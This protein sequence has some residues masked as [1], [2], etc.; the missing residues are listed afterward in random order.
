MKKT[1]ILILVLLPIILV[2]TIAFA[3]KILSYYHHIP[4]EKVDFVDDVSDAL[5]DDYFLKVNVNETKPTAIRIFPEM[6][7]NKKVSYSSQDESICTVDAEGNVTG[8]ATG[9]TS[10]M[11]TTS[12]GNKTDILKVL[13]VA[14]NV[15]GITLPYSELNMTIGESQMLIPTVEPY[16]ALNKN[17]TYSTS[18][19]SIVSVKPT[20][21]ITALSP[22]TATITVTSQANN[23]LSATCTITVEDGTPPLAFDL[24]VGTDV[25]I[26]NT[27]TIDLAPHLQHDERKI[28]PADIC[29]R[30][31]SGNSYATLDGTTVTFTASNKPVKITAY[32]GDASAPTYFTEI[33]LVYQP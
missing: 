29:W 19:S 32:V 8:V 10:V 15:T 18:D 26:L 7:T 13:V 33:R 1:V 14:E 6:A 27:N 5:P 20:G 11:V 4:V 23:E 22:G 9:N 12:D 24:V 30:I 16:T 3:G 21:Q 2:I 25:Y 28:D 31:S 17:V